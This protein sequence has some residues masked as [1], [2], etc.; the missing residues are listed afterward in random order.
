MG[1]SPERGGRARARGDDGAALVE[2]SLVMV[3]LFTLLFGII[4]CGLILS[5]QQDLTRAAAEGARAGAV[6]FPAD[7]AVD[8][9]DAALDEASSEFGGPNWDC[10]GCG[11]NERDGFDCLAMVEECPGLQGTGTMCVIVRL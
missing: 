6:A 10:T 1:L 8:E 2:F 9:A 5:F 3:L 7:I 11:T 4:S